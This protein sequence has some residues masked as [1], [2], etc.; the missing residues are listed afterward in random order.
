[1]LQIMSQLTQK[2]NGW[3]F[4]KSYLEPG[5]LMTRGVHSVGLYITIIPLR[6][7]LGLKW[8]LLVCDP[9]D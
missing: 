1:M 8:P 4:W 9:G 6:D 2:R 3:N 5:H 7:Y